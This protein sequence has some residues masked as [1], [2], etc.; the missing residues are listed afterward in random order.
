MG[1]LLEVGKVVELAEVG[2]LRNR[3]EVPARLLPMLEK[4]V[5]QLVSQG[6]PAPIPGSGGLDQNRVAQADSPCPGVEVAPS[7]GDVAGGD[8]KALVGDELDD[9]DRWSTYVSCL[10]ELGGRSP[11]EESAAVT[12]Q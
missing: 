7:V 2:G 8:G 11:D 10:E 6:E 12:G 9:R 4:A 1:L 3:S 5:A